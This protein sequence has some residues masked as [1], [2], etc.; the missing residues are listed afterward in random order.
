MRLVKNDEKAGC[1]CPICFGSLAWLIVEN[2][3]A[4]GATASSAA[5]L[6]RRKIAS[7]IA[8]IR[9]NTWTRV[10]RPALRAK[11]DNSAG[12]AVKSTGGSP[13]I[14]KRAIGIH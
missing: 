14:R 10:K 7:K 5:I 2:V 6:R 3:V 12:K 1:V 11:E 8:E 9:R 13:T 4:L